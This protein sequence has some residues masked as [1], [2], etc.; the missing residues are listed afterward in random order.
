MIIFAGLLMAVSC[1]TGPCVR[2]YTDPLTNQ[3]I[4]SA[5][6]NTP[7]SSPTPKPYRTPVPRVKPKLVK[8]V[9]KVLPKPRPKAT[10]WIPYQPRS[11]L[12]PTYHPVTKKTKKFVPVLTQVAT[13]AISLSDQVSRLLPGSQLMYQP[14]VDPIAGIPIYFWS[15]SNPVFQITTAILGIAVSVTLQPSFLWDFGDGHGLTTGS[16]GGAFPDSTIT[17]TYKEPGNFP[18]TLTISWAGSWSTA[19]EVLPVLGG[20]IVQTMST[21]V[22][23]SPG[24]TSYTA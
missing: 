22:L 13:A 10:K 5:K 21:N 12:R 3:V 7:G 11:V 1:S 18:V 17:H 2:V 8:P 9:V 20:A 24:P 19:G 4:I 15:D 6:Q 14:S 16:P 23:V